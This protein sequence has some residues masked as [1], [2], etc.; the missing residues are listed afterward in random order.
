[1]TR[2]QIVSVNMRATAETIQVGARLVETAIAKEPVE[3]AEVTEL[4]LVG[5]LIVDRKHHGGPDQAVYLYSR[6]DYAWWESELGASLAPG[7]F[8]ENLTCSSFGPQPVRIGDRFRIGG[9]TILQATAAR[10]PCGVFQTHMD[11]RA[12]VKRFAAA[13]RPGFYARVLAPGEVVAGDEI[14]PLGGGEAHPEIVTSLD[15]FYE[16]DP[17]PAVLRAL[18]DSPVAIRARVEYERKLAELGAAAG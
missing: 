7:S 8:G 9:P 1:M 3:R 17:D 4:G 14:E 2:V 18:L 11:E 10:V 5:D 13:R 6:E 16:S 15:V 12:W